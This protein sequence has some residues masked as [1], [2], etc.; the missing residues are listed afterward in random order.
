MA[1]ATVKKISVALE[2]DVAQA[3]ARAAERDGMSLSAWLNRAAEHELA[4]DAGLAAVRE[5]EE[6]FGA[7]TEAERTEARRTLDRSLRS[8]RRNATSS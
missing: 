6:E 8:A 1:A 3:A 2:P 7:F 4:I 5:Y